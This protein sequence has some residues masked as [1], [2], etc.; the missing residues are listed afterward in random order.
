MFF[1]LNSR[2]LCW[3]SSK[4]NGGGAVKSLRG[5]F[6]MKTFSEL[7]KLTFPR[8]NKVAQFKDISMCVKDIKVCCYMCEFTSLVSSAN[9]SLCPPF[10]LLK[11]LWKS[12]TEGHSCFVKK[13]KMRAVQWENNFN[14]FF[15][16][17]SQYIMI[18][19]ILQ[20]CWGMLVVLGGHP[21]NIGDG[22]WWF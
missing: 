17:N 22:Y 5:E 14:T 8:I 6:I 7:I 20:Q 13:Y 18:F 2:P 12:N 1:L 21:V 19:W 3:L 4:F 9:T 16:D 11:S 10:H 15:A